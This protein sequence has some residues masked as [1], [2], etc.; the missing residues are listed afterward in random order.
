MSSLARVAAM[1][2]AVAMISSTVH[3]QAAPSFTC[4]TRSLIVGAAEMNGMR[5]SCSVS[6]APAGD[7]TLRIVS[8]D[9]EPVCEVALNNGVATCVGTLISAVQPGQVLAELLPSGTQYQVL[10]PADSGQPSP[11]LQYTPLPSVAS[12]SGPDQPAPDSAS[13]T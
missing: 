11:Q 10:P 8:D 5:V 13:S 6:G 1:V 2:A 12:Q 9:P 3:A 7:Q 4:E